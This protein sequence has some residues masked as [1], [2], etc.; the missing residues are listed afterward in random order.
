MCS[1]IICLFLLFLKSILSEISVSIPF[2]FFFGYYLLEIS[3]QSM[4]D[5]KTRQHI[6]LC[7][8]AQSCLI[9][10][11][12]MGCSLPISSVHGDSPGKN[13]G[14]SCHALLQEIFQTQGLN[15][16]IPHCRWILYWEAPDS[17]LLNSLIHLYLK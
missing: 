12:P 15:S 17:I 13:T 6:V 9:L 8:V 14:V 11:D 5:F 4:C 16:G 1:K 3:L 2:F 10:C 7:L